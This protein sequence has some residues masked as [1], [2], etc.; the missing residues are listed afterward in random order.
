M[1]FLQGLNFSEM[2]HLE[3]LISMQL[4]ATIDNMSVLTAVHELHTLPTIKKWCNKFKQVNSD[5]V[6]SLVTESLHGVRQGVQ[7]HITGQNLAVRL[8]PLTKKQH[9]ILQKNNHI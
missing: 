9:K 7:F 3:V 4:I 6:L 5:T 2:G 8:R 1:L